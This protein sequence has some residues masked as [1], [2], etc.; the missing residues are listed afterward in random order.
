MF[1][2]SQQPASIRYR[3]GED[4]RLSLSASFGNVEIGAPCAERNADTSVAAPTL[5]IP[6]PMASHRGSH[7]AAGT[8]TSVGSGAAALR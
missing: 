1:V 5:A 7:A 8:K 6:D 3:W 4:K 2:L